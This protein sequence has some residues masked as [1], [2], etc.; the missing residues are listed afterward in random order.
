MSGSPATFSVCIRGACKAD[1]CA[2]VGS[3]TTEKLIL[4]VYSRLLA[5]PSTKVRLTVVGNFD[6]IKSVR[7]VFLCSMQVLSPQILAT[8]L[9]PTLL[10]LKNDRDWRIRQ[11]LL[12]LIPL[13]SEQLGID[14]MARELRPI[15][16]EWVYRILSMSSYTTDTVAAVRETAAEILKRL[17]GMYGEEFAE[18]TLLPTLSDLVHNEKYMLRITG[19][20]IIAVR[21]EGGDDD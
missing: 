5:D 7:F 4:P 6:K 18:N 20:N 1:V 2:I 9:L 13:L 14:I 11:Y 3:E 16:C 15:T 12:T 19:L 10:S 8:S 17:Y 21:E